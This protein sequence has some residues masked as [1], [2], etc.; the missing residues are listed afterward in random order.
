[1]MGLGRFTPGKSVCTAQLYRGGSQVHV[2]GIHPP[3]E[4]PALRKSRFESRQRL[5]PCLESHRAEITTLC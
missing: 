1:M 4:L 5:L 2:T 3:R